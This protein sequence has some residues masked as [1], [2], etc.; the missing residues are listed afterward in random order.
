MATIEQNYDLLISVDEGF[1]S[2]KIVVNGIVFNIPTEMFKVGDDPGFIGDRKGK[3][4]IGATI[5]NTKYIVGSD[6]RILLT[7][8]VNKQD[9]MATLVERLTYDFLTSLKGERFLTTCIGLAIIKYSEYTKEKNI[10]PKLEAKIM[11]DENNK[12]SI[13]INENSQW[14]IW[15]IIGYPHEEENE[16]FKEI[17]PRIVGR[18][19]IEIE[20]RNKTYSLDFTI[21]ETNVMSYSQAKAAFMG[22]VTDDTGKWKKMPKGESVLDHL[23]CLVIDGGQK[24]VG[25]YLISETLQILH[26]E[27]NTSYAMNN[28]YEAVIED[29]KAAGRDDILVNNLSEYLNNGKRLN[30][31]GENGKAQTINVNELFN[32]RKDEYCDKLI[33]HINEK[34]RDMLDLSSILIS[35][36]TGAAYFDRFKEYVTEYKTE[37]LA[38]NTSITK[39]D[40]MGQEITPENAIAIG[41]YKVLSHEVE[42]YK[43]SNK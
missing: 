21:K 39:Y 43:K 20:Q 8:S 10:S 3:N 12:W 30:V 22:C 26:A 1:N 7:D 9:N 4:Y 31:I 2:G 25:I 41:L 11:A 32:K 16:I 40:F 5:Q 14:N 13:N 17:L 33:T 27:S 35:G 34:F 24:T 6:A 36:G 18:K 19:Q 38:Q 37:D 29:I 28:V 15:L 23:P 42:N